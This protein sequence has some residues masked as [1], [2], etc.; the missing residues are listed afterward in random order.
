VARLL[1]ASP[2][3]RLTGTFANLSCAD[4]PGRAETGEQVNA[5]ASCAARLREAGIDPGIVHAAN[6]AGVLA[7]PAS[8]LGGV[9]PGLAL[10]GIEPAEGLSGGALSPAMRIE[11]DVVAVRR[12]PA[13]TP[14]GYGGR[15]VTERET[16][17]AVLSIGYHDGFRRGFSGRVAV[18]LRGRPAP[19]VGSV[20]MDL[21]L[22]DATATGAERGDRAVCLGEEGGGSVTA[23]E[24]AR[25]AETIPYEILCGF[26][27]RLERLFVE[28]AAE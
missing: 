16:T 21:T 13:G 24:L 4:D 18:L 20:S 8:W 9:R 11:A 28:R 26:G 10:Y 14:L 3:L 6:S 22:V 17:I 12:V 7:H 25:A 1:A 19:V 27:S 5:L 2:W 23:W 15:F